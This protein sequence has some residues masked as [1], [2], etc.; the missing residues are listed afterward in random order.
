MLYLCPFEQTVGVLA[1]FKGIP[2]PEYG[3]ESTDSVHSAL[4]EVGGTY[5][6]IAFMMMIGGA[7]RKE[8]MF[9]S[10]E[11]DEPVS[12]SFANKTQGA[13]YHYLSANFLVWGVENKKFKVPGLEIEEDATGGSNIAKVKIMALKMLHDCSVGVPE[14]RLPQNHYYI[15]NEYELFEEGEQAEDQEAEEG[16]VTPDIVGVALE[17]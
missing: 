6:H 15:Q 14:E 7:L 5:E 11:N 9:Y 3:A 8:G 1:K 2:K 16:P 12:I 13:A 17:V 10:A 4:R